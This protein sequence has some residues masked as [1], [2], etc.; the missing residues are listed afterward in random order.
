MWVGYRG[1]QPDATGKR[2]GGVGMGGST[3]QRSH[4]GETATMAP[5]P[6]A[7]A[8]GRAVPV[9]GRRNLVVSAIL[10]VVALVLL[11]AF[12]VRFGLH[13]TGGSR[14]PHF[15]YQAESF[16]QG[17]WDVSLPPGTNDTAL[18]GGKVYVLYPPFPAV[19]LLPFVALF[20]LKTSDILFTTILSAANLGL[21]YLLLEQVR[22]NGLSR[23]IWLE[24]VI[25]S[26]LLFFGSINLW[27]SLGGKMWFTAQIVCMTCTLLSLLLAF[28]GHFVW[29]AALLGCAFFS[30][31]TLLLGFPFLFYLTWQAGGTEHLVEQFFRSLRARAPE[32][33]AVPWRRLAGVAAVLL[34][35][36]GLYLARNWAVFGS[37]FENGY[38]IVLHQE[39]LYRGATYGVFSWHYVP[40]NLIA[41]FFS[42][43]RIIFQG[44]EDRHPVIDL[45]NTG[46]AVSVFV[47][48]PLF[49]LL[50]WRNRRFSLSRAL[51]WGT[52][53]LLVVAVLLFHQAGWYQFGA[54]YLYDG[55]PYAFLLLAL[56]EVRVDWRF[57]LLGIIGIAINAMGAYEFWT[58]KLIHL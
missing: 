58:S 5:A 42:F 41:N 53:A 4:G 44:P 27:L 38:N 32:W 9:F 54:R 7:R 28:R 57:A 47:T 18:I 6:E 24:N 48:T 22:A 26:V 43:P 45:L 25:I 50:F 40:A 31:A 23:R 51:L 30:R 39:R 21:L 37:P 29:S 56:N 34:A 10:F 11:W 46:I 13:I 2:K 19:A 17:R 8:G 55:Y 16:L 12:E 35:V 3:R 15:I 33:A 49:L 14:A 1:R 36:I 52:L 20:G